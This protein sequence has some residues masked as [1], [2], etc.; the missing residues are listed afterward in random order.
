MRVGYCKPPTP[1]VVAA[2]VWP[3]LDPTLPLESSYIFD[4][5][6]F[7]ISLASVGV[8]AQG[9][10]TPNLLQQPQCSAFCIRFSYSRLN[11]HR[12]FF[13]RV[14]ALCCLCWRKEKH[15]SGGSVSLYSIG[16]EPLSINFVSVFRNAYRI[17]VERPSRHELG[18]TLEIKISVQDSFAWICFHWMEKPES[19]KAH[20]RPST[21][22]FRLQL[23][24]IF[25][26]Q[27]NISGPV[28][29]LFSEILR[30]FWFFVL[31][32]G[33][34]PDGLNLRDIRLVI[35]KYWN[36]T[37]AVSGYP[38]RLE[39]R[40]GSLEPSCWQCMCKLGSHDTSMSKITPQPCRQMSL[41]GYLTC[42][43]MPIV[44]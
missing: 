24:D 11:Y 43:S 15:I 39:Y 28:K 29:G 31:F 34:L 36:K 13:S 40:G 44:T 1:F 18:W 19:S 30:L 38:D 41:L 35:H 7:S 20:A 32:W 26:T 9:E 23:H 5:E 21:N 27:Y 17:W 22:S 14:D 37:T 8:R 6:F 25:S 12:I 33:V 3:L 16:W 2:G 4:P 10:Y 42:F